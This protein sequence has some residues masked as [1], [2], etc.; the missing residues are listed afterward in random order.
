M[1][2]V[3]QQCTRK[4]MQDTRKISVQLTGF[5]FVVVIL[6]AVFQSYSVALAQWFSTFFVPRLVIAT[7]Y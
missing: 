2:E 5:W 6:T 7:H 4:L 1:Q 3:M